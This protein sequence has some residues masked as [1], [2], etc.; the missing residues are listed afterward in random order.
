MN[1]KYIKV[2][3]S[4]HEGKLL[5]TML[6]RRE[7]YLMPSSLIRSCKAIIKKLEVALGKK[8]LLAERIREELEKIP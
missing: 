1:I 6:N 3:L 7:V 4:E 2:E 8:Q 5:L